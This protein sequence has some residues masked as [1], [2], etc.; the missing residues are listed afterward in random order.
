MVIHYRI[1]QLRQAHRWL[2]KELASKLGVSIE[3]VKSWEQGRS[4][5]DSPNRKKLA[6]IFRVTEADLFI[7]GTENGQQ[8]LPKQEG[9]MAKITFDLRAGKISIEGAESELLTILQE[10]KTLA[11]KFKNIVISSSGQGSS[12]GLPEDAQ[13]LPATRKPAMRDFGRSLSLGNTY[14]RI[15]ALAYHA[16]KVESRMSFSPKE[17]D[18]W[19]GLC[20]F[21]K[22]GNMRVAL[23]DAKSKYGYVSSKGYAQWTIATGGENLIMEKLEAKEQ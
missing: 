16:I 23:A 1:K 7:E 11:P 12:E 8:G 4:V 21:K 19:F 18:D 13:Q 9:A 2:Q 6:A 17:M 10:A 14:E 20:G 22:P 5:P 15:A 3:T